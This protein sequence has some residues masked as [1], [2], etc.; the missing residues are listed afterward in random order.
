MRKNNLTLVIVLSLLSTVIF[1]QNAGTNFIKV[2]YQSTP[3]TRYNVKTTKEKKRVF[4]PKK[5]FWV[6]LMITTVFILTYQIGRQ[7][8]S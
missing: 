4:I 3:L 1:A 6:V 7:Y 2:Q 5:R 8:M